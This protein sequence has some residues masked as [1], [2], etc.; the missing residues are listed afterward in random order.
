VAA[1][2]GNLDTFIAEV[3]DAVKWTRMNAGARTPS[4]GDKTV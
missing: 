2:I 1:E 4:K 3:A